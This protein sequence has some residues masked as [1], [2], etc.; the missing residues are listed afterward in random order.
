MVVG[1]GDPEGYG[2]GTIVK[3]SDG[4]RSLGS[5]SGER[6]EKGHKESNRR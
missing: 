2:Y 5:V 4:H 3:G 6:K 1:S